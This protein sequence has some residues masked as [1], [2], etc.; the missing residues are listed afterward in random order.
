MTRLEHT[1]VNLGV[2]SRRTGLTVL[3]HL[4]REVTIPVLEGIQAQGDLIVIPLPLVAAA[5]SPAN[6]THWRMVPA[7]G[8]ELL[9]SAAGGNAHTL[10]ADRGT[11]EYLPSPDDNLGL[12]LGMF[13]SSA[14]VYLLHPEH[15][16]AGFTPGDYVVRRQREYDHRRRTWSGGAHRLVA[17]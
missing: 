1:T 4:E 6:R 5:V 2:L 14:P 16:A 17:D 9:R 11:C 13:H 7:K 12:A 10:V 15:G 8:L 3:D